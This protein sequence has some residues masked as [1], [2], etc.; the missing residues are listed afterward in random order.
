MVRQSIVISAIVTEL[1]HYSQESLWAI[2]LLPT[3]FGKSTAV[4]C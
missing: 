3:A 4:F 1:L 2:A